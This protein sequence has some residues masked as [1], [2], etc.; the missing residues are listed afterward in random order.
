MHQ[1]TS[2][3]NILDNG[4]RNFFVGGSIIGSGDAT[5]NLQA[6]GSNNSIGAVSVKGSSTANV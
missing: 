6:S 3:I 2:Q 4:N 1:D 5:I